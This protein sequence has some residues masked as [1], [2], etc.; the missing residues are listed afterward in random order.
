M[1][2]H[3]RDSTLITHFDVAE[4]ITLQKLMHCQLFLD[5]I[6]EQKNDYIMT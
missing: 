1:Y 2:T 3:T 5:L 4:L 6:T